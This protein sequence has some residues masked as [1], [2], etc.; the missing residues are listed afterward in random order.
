M[1]KAWDI[2]NFYPILGAEM[3]VTR[4]TTVSL[5]AT[6]NYPSQ[7]KENLRGPGVSI[8]LKRYFR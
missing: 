1:D 7:Q 2:L 8:A 5:A 4:D 6:Y 3:P